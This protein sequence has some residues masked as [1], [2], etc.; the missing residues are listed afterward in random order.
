MKSNRAFV[1]NP[2]TVIYCRAILVTVTSA[3]RVKR[4]ICKT[5]TG[6]LENKKVVFCP[7]FRTILP[8]HTPRQ[9][10]HQCFQCLDLFTDVFLA[11]RIISKLITAGVKDRAMTV[12]P[13]PPVLYH[14]IY[15]IFWSC[16]IAKLKVCLPLL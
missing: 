8:A 7:P 3:C 2:S 12:K 5:W 16:V 10:T 4:V 9:L 1:R 15:Y 14:S 11:S 6:S 13:L